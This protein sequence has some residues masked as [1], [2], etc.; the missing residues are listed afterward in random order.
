MEILCLSSTIGDV[1][2]DSH[3]EEPFLSPELKHHPGAGETA[4]PS[5][6]PSWALSYPG[7][8]H[9]SPNPPSPVEESSDVMALPAGSSAP[10][11]PPP[12]C[13]QSLRHCD[14]QQS[15]EGA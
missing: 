1:K 11:P 13:G 12:S 2:G 9:P 3:S 4:C 7:P 5:Q 6:K 15:K 8:S 10:P 14:S